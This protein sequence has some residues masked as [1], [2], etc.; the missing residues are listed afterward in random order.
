MTKDLTYEF[1]IISVIISYNHEKFIN[2]TIE[3]V[4][5]QNLSYKNHIVIID[6]ASTDATPEIIKSYR[7]KFPLKI[8]TILKEKNIGVEKIIS[9]FYNFVK[10]KSKYLT[11]I[12]GDDYW[13]NP[14]KLQKQID[15]LEQNKDYAGCFHDASILSSNHEIG[16]PE[17]AKT[18][19]HSEYK[20]Y[21]QFNR[22]VSDF[23]PWHLMARNIIPTASLVFYNNT[24]D[25]IIGKF[26]DINL[27]L[28]WGIHL[29]LIRNS[30][31]RYFN[32]VWSVYNDH[33]EGFSKKFEYNKFKISNVNIIKRLYKYNFYSWHDIDLN[34]AII[35]E[36]RQILFNPYTKK[37][38]FG[39]LLLYFIK[40]FHRSFLLVHLEILHTLFQYLKKNN[41]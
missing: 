22:Y 27:S 20:T 2:K 38:S 34:L 3:S 37:Q 16:A 24:L 17:L 31:F 21:S 5:D 11:V 35:K 1:D 10:N 6:D 25:D 19:T 7:D 33:P 15:F 29:Y 32:E 14:L 8:S 9:E 4:L 12:E 40:Y 23:C 36:Y 26:S 30:K 39:F 13:S 28:N 41:K 18:Q